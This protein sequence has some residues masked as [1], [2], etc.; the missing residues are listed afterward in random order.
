LFFFS[1]KYAGELHIIALRRGKAKIAKYTHHYTPKTHT[2]APA[3]G[4]SNRHYIT[5]APKRT[6]TLLGCR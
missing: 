4:G 5:L 2:T 6:T 3:I 1:S